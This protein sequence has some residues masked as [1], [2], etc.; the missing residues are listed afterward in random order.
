MAVSIKDI[1][2]IAGV[3][4]MTVS[5][6]INNPDRVNSGT[7]EKVLRIIS[8]YGYRPNKSALSL[9]SGKSFNIGLLILYDVK[10]FPG[11]FL[12]PILIGLTSVLVDSGYNLTLYF[13]QYNG[14]K[15]LIKDNLLASHTVDGVIVISVESD[16]ELA[17][18]IGRIK[19]PVVL[20]NQNLNLSCVSSVG[21]DDFGGAD[22]AVKYLLGKGHTR[23]GFI[24]G[25]EKY[26]TSRDR[27][28]GY[29][30]AL[31]EAGI[32][33]GP[34]FYEIGNFSKEGG[35]R[36]MGRMM[37]RAKGMTAVFCANDAM[38][39][40]AYKA[41][42]E[43]NMKI[44]GDISVIGFDNQDFSA[45]IDPELTT[46]EKLRYQMGSEAA[47]MMLDNLRESKP[48]GIHKTLPTRLIER[49][50]VKDINAP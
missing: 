12:P 24:G 48:G 8:E 14:K 18:R 26:S 5:R 29:Y 21:C 15:N 34:A 2:R 3:S 50:S 37:K 39:L 35:Y 11:D 13:D 31:E 7:R 42:H 40:G 27:K 1:A 41:I 44:P 32:K 25:S 16:V 17:Y 20:V 47:L 33:L 46:V 4:H 36:A 43:N 23:I 6:V 49:A 30:K 22:E 38:A 19:V 9:L 28:S 10:Q 45:V